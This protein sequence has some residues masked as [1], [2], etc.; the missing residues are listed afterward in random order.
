M[1][2][3]TSLGRASSGKV[4]SIMTRATRHPDTA[5]WTHGNVQTE[6]DRQSSEGHLNGAVVRARRHAVDLRNEGACLCSRHH[7]TRS[8]GSL[9]N[10]TRGSQ[11]RD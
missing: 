4:D 5:F 3:G 9:G 8:L 7:L 2:L 11:R 10:F 1:D 6:N